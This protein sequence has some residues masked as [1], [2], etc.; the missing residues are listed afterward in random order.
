MIGT[1]AAML[2]R[3]LRNSRAIENFSTQIKPLRDFTRSYN[4]T[5]YRTP[6]PIFSAISLE[7]WRLN[8]G[9]RSECRTFK[10]NIHQM[11]GSY[12]L[13]HAFI[14][15]YRFLPWDPI[16]R[17]HTN[18]RADSR[19]QSSQWE[20]SLQSNAVS[21][22]L[23]AKLESMMASSNGNIFRVAG[24]LCGEFTGPPWIPRTKA[25]DAELWCFLWSAS[26]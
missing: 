21:P 14:P 26:E 4:T 19:L 5:S 2:L 23:C 7:A 12:S 25:S 6:P 17:T 13:S 3:R 1:L 8:V 11:G 18:Y 20:T 15:L 24:H 22:C 9:Y 10:T 16:Y